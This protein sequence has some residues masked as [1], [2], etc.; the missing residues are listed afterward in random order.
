[1][2]ILKE[3]KRFMVVAM[4][5]ACVFISNNMNVAVANEIGY[6]GMGRGDRQPGCDHG[7]CPPDQPANPYHRGCE[8]SKRCRGPD[9]PALPRKMI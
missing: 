8:K 7:N 6:P 9:P 2:S 5:I 1:M 3:T 4:F